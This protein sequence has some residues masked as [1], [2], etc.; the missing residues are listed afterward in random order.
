[1]LVAPLDFQ[2]L[3]LLSAVQQLLP[4]MLL[5]P[6][7]SAP[8]SSAVAP[9]AVLLWRA[10][11][12]VWLRAGLFLSLCCC[13]PCM[14]LLLLSLLLNLIGKLSMYMLLL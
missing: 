11:A 10:A 1:M 5:L 7:L 6:A 3:R 12:H 14:V 9:L 2:L 8:L 4:L 13:R